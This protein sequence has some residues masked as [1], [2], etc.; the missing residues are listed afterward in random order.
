MSGKRKFAPKDNF[1]IVDDSTFLSKEII[2]KGTGEDHPFEGCKVLYR[3]TPRYDANDS[4]SSIPG[5]PEV[6][7]LGCYSSKLNSLEICLTSM[8]KGEKSLFTKTTF[9]FAMGIMENNVEVSAM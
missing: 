5:P 8:K 9:N 7:K 6:L 4:S 2:K 3:N 1:K